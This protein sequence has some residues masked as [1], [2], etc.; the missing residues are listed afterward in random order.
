MIRRF[1][2]YNYKDKE[3]NVNDYITYMLA[4]TTTMFKYHNL[5][6]TIPTNILEGMLQTYGY[7]NIIKEGGELYCLVGSPTGERDVYD[8]P[9]QYLITNR[10]LKL[11]GKVYEVGK[12]TVVID[13][14]NMRIGLLPLLSRYCTQLAESDVTMILA[15]INKRMQTLICAG[16]NTTLQSARTYIKKI[17]EGELGIIADNKMFD[18]LKTNTTPTTT[19]MKDLYEFHQYIKGSMYN[20]LGLNSNYNMKR[21][22]ITSSEIEMNSDGLYPLVD[23]MLSCRRIAL[24]KINEMFGTNIEVE[25]NSSWDYRFQHGEPIDTIGIETDVK[26]GKEPADVEVNKEGKEPE[27]TTELDETKESESNKSLNQ[28]DKKQG[29]PNGDDKE[30]EDKR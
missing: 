3:K 9:L 23:S 6:E 13:N 19:N 4:R 18:S 27:P 5:P 10:H 24:N 22:F 12:D 8:E 11:N 26:E 2:N 14:D 21:E 29:D 16:D 15:S 20:E 28:I 1:G 7:C 17:E 30:N 25:F